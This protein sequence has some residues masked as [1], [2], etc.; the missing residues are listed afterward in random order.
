MSETKENYLYVYDMVVAMVIKTSIL[1]VPCLKAWYALRKKWRPPIIKTGVDRT[2]KIKFSNDKPG[3]NIAICW[4]LSSDISTIKYSIASIQG[5]PNSKETK[6]ALRHFWISR[7]CSL[8]CMV[9][10]SDVDVKRSVSKP[11]FSISSAIVRTSITCVSWS[12]WPLCIASDTDAFN[13]PCNFRTRVS[14]LFTHDA[15]VIPL[16]NISLRI[17]FNY[18]FIITGAKYV[19][20]RQKWPP[21]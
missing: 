19:D 3:I 7:L 11:I 1:V 21:L 10:F 12:N 9:R 18:I 14:I 5:P 13:T 2:N 20:R 17:T 4:W 6:N 8:Y 15:H 16:M